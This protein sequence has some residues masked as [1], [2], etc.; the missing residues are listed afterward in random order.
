MPGR[1]EKSIRIDAAPKDVFAYVSDL[2]RHP[3]WATNPLEVTVMTDGPIAV[4]TE[5]RSAGKLGGTHVDAGRI[6]ELEPPRRLVFETTGFAGTVRNWLVVEPDGDGCVL[7]KGSEMTRVSMFS[8]VMTPM[9][10][11]MIPRMYVR[12]LKAIKDRVEKRAPTG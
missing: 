2:R 7:T 3:E 6:V 12:N 8:R 9:L 10:H 1:F 5:F 4:G 11:L